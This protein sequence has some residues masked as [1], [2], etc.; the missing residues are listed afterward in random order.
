MTVELPTQASLGRDVLIG[1]ALGA[2][3]A[4]YDV[5]SAGDGALAPLLAQR[6]SSGAKARMLKMG[7]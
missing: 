1:L 7:G 5:L 6:T 2:T 3:R 4:L